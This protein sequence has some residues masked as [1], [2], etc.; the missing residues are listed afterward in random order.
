MNTFI[1]NEL[2][3]HLAEETLFAQIAAFEGEVFREVE[4]RRTLKTKIGEGF[5]FAK[6]HY[7]VGWAEIIKNL[8]QMRLPVL[9][10]RNEFEAIEALTLAGVPTMSTAAFV[11]RGWNPAMLRSAIVTRAL[12]DTISLEDFEPESPL[13]KRTLLQEIA[14]IARRMHQAGINHRDFYLCHFL[15]AV[16]S[17]QAPV[18]HLIDLHRAQMRRSVPLRWQVKDLGGLLFSA[19]DKSLTKRD[20]LRF[21][22]IYSDKPLRTALQEDA[23]LWA[24]VIDRACRLYLQDHNELPWDIQKLLELT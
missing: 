18:L 17:Q 24:D 9:S 16:G 21:V 10:A 15:M 12:E 22:R 7:G 1:A 19:F 6:I 3:P 5:Y 23:G 14:L 8:L 2:Q 20:L 11:E 4:Q 13:I